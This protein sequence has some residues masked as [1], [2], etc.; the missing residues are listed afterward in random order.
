MSKFNNRFTL[1][2]LTAFAVLTA[3]L[4]S[5]HFGPRYAAGS[6]FSTIAT[7][8]ALTILTAVAAFLTR[9]HDLS[10]LF[11]QN[12]NFSVGFGLF[13][14]EEIGWFLWRLGYRWEVFE[15]SL[16]P[17]FKAG[18]GAAWFAAFSVMGVYLFFQKRFE[19][20]RVSLATSAAY[21]ML[22][23]FVALLFV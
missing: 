9:K 23:T 12:T 17:F 16:S 21:M 6:Y 3:F 11:W 1:S 4:F 18:Q 13:T 15:F 8:T 10:F 19:F 5:L 2:A 22:S 7:G 14:L 20:W